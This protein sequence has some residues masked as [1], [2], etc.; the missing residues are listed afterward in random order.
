MYTT[1]LIYNVT[2]FAK[3]SLVRT[4]IKIHFLTQL[5]ATLNSYTHSMSPM[6]RLN[7]S[8]FLGGGF[9]ALYNHD[10]H[11]GTR[12]AH[13]LGVTILEFYPGPEWCLFGLVEWSGPYGATSDPV[14][15]PGGFSSS[16]PAPPPSYPPPHNSGPKLMHTS[17]KIVWKGLKS[18]EEQLQR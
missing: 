14:S 10:R 4:K 6:A 1:S 12:G 17:E 2:V 13:Q 5:I 15:S 7:R 18:S 16:L 9:T 3:T 11:I 8:A